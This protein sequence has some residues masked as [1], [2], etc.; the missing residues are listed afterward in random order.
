MASDGHAK[1]SGHGGE[2]DHKGHAPGG[3]HNHAPPDRMTRAFGIGI[4]RIHHITIQLE[5]SWR[6]R[7]RASIGRVAVSAFART[8]FATP[9]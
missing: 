4:A 3:G 5:R 9:W 8:D 6:C 1:D 2:G 7:V